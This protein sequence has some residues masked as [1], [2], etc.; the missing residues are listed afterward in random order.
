MKKIIKQLFSV[1]AVFTMMIL[2]LEVF[3]DGDTP[4]HITDS[5]NTKSVIS[6]NVSVSGNTL[7]ISGTT[8]EGMLAV[9]VAIYNESGKKLITMQTAAVND[10]N[11]YET[12]IEAADGTYLVKVADY[13]GGKY[14]TKLVTVGNPNKNK[15][16]DSESQ[17]TENT[18]KTTEDSKKQG[19]KVY[20][21]KTADD[22]MY[23]LIMST[24]GMVST[25][26]GYM[27]T[28]KKYKHQRT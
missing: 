3:A 4:T 14:L 7:L 21:P 11:S 12:S 16:K 2:C 27:L 10:E 18:D 20:F 26:V 9:A 23:I 17:Q 28:K 5:D 15:S 24:V 8:E 19:K 13:Q 25:L 1:F 22:G 6:L